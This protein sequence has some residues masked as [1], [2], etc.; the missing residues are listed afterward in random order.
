MRDKTIQ[1][2]INVF[3]KAFGNTPPTAPPY[4]AAIGRAGLNGP[5]PGGAGRLAPYT[6]LAVEDLPG[7]TA[8]E[9]QKLIDAGAEMPAELKDWF[10]YG[11][12]AALLFFGAMG[13]LLTSSLRRCR[14]ARSSR[15]WST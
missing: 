6:G 12:P 13:L 8:A 2:V 15:R 14:T 7:L 9:K 3:A 11:I 1:A 4:I 10:N 5:L